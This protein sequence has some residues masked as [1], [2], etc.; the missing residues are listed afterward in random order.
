MSVNEEYMDGVWFQVC[1]GVDL[2]EGSEMRGK[3]NV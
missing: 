1:S 2:C 3:W